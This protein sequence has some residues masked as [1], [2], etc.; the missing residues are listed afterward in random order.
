MHDQHAADA[1]SID[2]IPT[3]STQNDVAQ[4]SADQVAGH[5]LA[6]LRLERFRDELHQLMS[7][8]ILSEDQQLARDQQL[9]NMGLTAEDVSEITQYASRLSLAQQH[10]L[11]QL[12]IVS[13]LGSMNT[14][15]TLTKTLSTETLS[16]NVRYQSKKQGYFRNRVQ[17]FRL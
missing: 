16:E 4:Y 7:A 2:F 8:I 11:Q 17:S 1:V 14:A 15:P 10:E 5:A 13:R 3:D 9:F 6:Q 12:S